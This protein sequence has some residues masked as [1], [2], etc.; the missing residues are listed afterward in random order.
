MFKPFFEGLLS[1]AR[2]KASSDPR[3]VGLLAGGSLMTGTLDEFSDLDL[4]VVYDAAYREEILEERLH[5]AKSLGPLLSAFTGE[6]VGEPRLLICLYDFK[7]RLLHVDLKFVSVPEL[8]D[9]MEDPVILWERSGEVKKVLLDTTCHSENVDI[10]WME[11]RFWVWIHYCATKLGRGELFEV[12]DSLAFIR[13]SVLGPLIQVK[14]GK[15]PRGVR[16]L[17]QLN[18]QTVIRLKDTLPAH[19]PKSCYRAIKEAIKI[20]RELR[21][22]YP[23]LEP[24][25]DA[26]D[27]VVPYLDRVYESFAL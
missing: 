26:E 18:S 3:F 12:I 16:R 9:R 21:Q 15:L 14:N 27:K 8:A 25:L 5:Y 2:E 19:T 6:H 24:R 1:Q 11:D 13:S 20:Y 7:G 22:D 23:E 10:Q 4:I 17:E